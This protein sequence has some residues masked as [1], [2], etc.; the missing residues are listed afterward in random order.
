MTKTSGRDDALLDHALL[1]DY[2]RMSVEEAILMCRDLVE[3]PDFPTVQ[4][5]RD[6]G[7]KVVGHFQVYFPEEIVHAAGM[8]PFKVLGATFAARQPAAQGRPVL[9]RIRPPE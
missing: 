3:D 8:L 2:S 4:K 1:D 9:R 5:W 6:A 7:G